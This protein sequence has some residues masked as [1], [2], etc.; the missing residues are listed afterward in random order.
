MTNLRIN[1][2][3]IYCSASIDKWKIYHQSLNYIID[4]VNDQSM[5][6]MLEYFILNY[7]AYDVLMTV[8]SSKL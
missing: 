8:L 3:L 5:S 6:K 7:D 2:F 4:S 1:K